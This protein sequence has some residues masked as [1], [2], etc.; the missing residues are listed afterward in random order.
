M[1]NGCRDWRSLM[2]EAVDGAIGAEDRG[3][4][5]A[6]LAS[7]EACRKDL[8]SLGS[9]VAALE[10][11]P[12]PE[13]RASFAADTVRRAS[14]ALIARKRRDRI[15]S[16]TLGASVAALCAA[17]VGTWAEV[18]WP[19]LVG[20]AGG[21]PEA[22]ASILPLA[23]AAAILGRVLAPLGGAAATL[24]WQGIASLAP[25]Y[26]LAFAALALVSIMTR[27]RRPVVLPVLSV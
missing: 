19:S 24:A 7:C 20:I 23:G 13:P 18:L 25:L 26:A 9:L 3:R 8:D 1:A 10:A 12:A 14:A 5:D 2:E 27:T 17:A 21:L 16:W 6:H 4:L 22:L 15:L 11:L